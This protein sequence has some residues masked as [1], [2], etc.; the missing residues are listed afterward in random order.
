MGSDCYSWGSGGGYIEA[1]CQ[2]TTH[3]VWVYRAGDFHGQR[4]L[5]SLGGLSY[6]TDVKV[7][8]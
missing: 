2:G 5:E 4:A 7:G 8:P 1:A 3:N 6:P